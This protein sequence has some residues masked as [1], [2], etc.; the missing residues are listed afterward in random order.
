MKRGSEARDAPALPPPIWKAIF[1]EVARE[2]DIYRAPLRLVCRDWRAWATVDQK[3]VHH[4][5]LLM[6]AAFDGLVEICKLAR[7]WMIADYDEHGVTYGTGPPPW[8]PITDEMAGTGVINDH[9]NVVELARE[10]GARPHLMIAE[11]AWRGNVG[12][13]K[14]AGEWGLNKSEIDA[15]LRRGFCGGHEDVCQL[16]VEWGARDFVGMLG[17]LD[18][19]DKLARV[20]LASKLMRDLSEK[21]RGSWASDA[22]LADCYPEFRVAE[23]SSPFDWSDDDDENRVVESPPRASPPR[24]SKSL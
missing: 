17:S 18:H 5:R 20:D 22:R 4:G 8:W 21:N 1:D 6:R 16:A 7:A 24:R 13:C 14:Y 15:M 23:S 10:W 12:M 9:A 3:E 2:D 19:A 11:A